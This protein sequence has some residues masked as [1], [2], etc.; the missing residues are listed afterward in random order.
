MK[1]ILMIIGLAALL[2]SC[3]YKEDYTPRYLQY[4]LSTFNVNM[5]DCSASS[6]VGILT[7]ADAARKDT[8]LNAA[9]DTTFVS[10]STSAGYG[11]YDFVSEINIV[12]DAADSTWTFATTADAKNIAFTGTVKMQRRDSRGNPVFEAAYSGSYTEDGGFSATYASDGKVSMYWME[13][14][15]YNPYY[16]SLNYTL[17]KDGKITLTTFYNGEK[18]DDNTVVLSGGDASYLKGE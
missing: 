7:H 12:R 1:K 15:Y 16:G 2:A 13:N 14:N 9:Y 17:F 3:T 8:I 11:Y 4:N 18:L 5:M 6:V 10:Y